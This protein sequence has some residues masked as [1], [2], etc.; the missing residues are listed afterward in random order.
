MNWTEILE[1]G[2]VPEPPGYHETVKLVTARTY[3][4]SS[5]KQKSKCKKK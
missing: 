1:R 2:G 4:K 5:Q 3:I